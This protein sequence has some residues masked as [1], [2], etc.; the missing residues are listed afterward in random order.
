MLRN[1]AV[2]VV[3]GALF[4][5]VAI[6]NVNFFLSKKASVGYRNADP[7]VP[8]SGLNKTGNPAG[9]SP[10]PVTQDK[11]MWKRDPFAYKLN[12]S[13]E[14]PDLSAGI[15][16]SERPHLVLKGIVSDIFGEYI[17]YIEIDGAKAVP[18]RKGDKLDDIKV[19]DISSRN[20]VLKWNGET[21]NLSNGTVKTIDEPRSK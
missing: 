18:M 13:S 11:E 17:C 14:R 2:M 6:Y 7:A 12:V 5:V 4:A 1:K 3:V 19:I 10:F 9:T 8:T 20:V 21:I 16:P 15:F